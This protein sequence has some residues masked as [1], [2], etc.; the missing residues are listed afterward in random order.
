M[1]P[2]HFLSLRD[3]APDEWADLL[4]TAELLSG[5]AG[6]QPLLAGRRF[7]M[8]F[9]NPS[10]R[11]RTSFEV[12]S[13]DLGAHAVYL[14]VGGGLWN[15]EARDD[16]VMDGAAAEHVRE[17]IP[18][19]A[20][21]VDAIGV[22]SFAEMKDPAEDAKD[23]VLNAIADA[24]PVPVLSLESAMDHPHQGLADALTVRRLYGRDKIKV[25]ITWAPHV[26]P[27]PRAV[28][29]GA[30]LA[31]AREG[32][33]ITVAHPEGYELDPGLIDEAEGIA[34]MAGGSIRFTNDQQ[35][36]VAGTRIVYAKSWGAPTLY[37]DADAQAASF[38]EHKDWIIDDLTLLDTDA[39]YFMHCLP[40]RRGVVVTDSVVESPMSAVV[41]Q[42]KARLDVQK[43][44][45]CKAMGVNPED[46]S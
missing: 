3:L 40:V 36:A 20:Q 42:G 31:F 1:D 24:S 25:T 6:K 23:G 21:M 10:L 43:A 17:A 14:Q 8:L 4:D 32:H 22:R 39:A 37:G 29:H 45:L 46:A 19:L 13:H 38:A 28:A 5:P 18:V 34:G 15:L 12:A 44:T 2:W 30:L 26:K 11:T 33:K 27:L 7:G 41:Q 35:D 16:V 9:F